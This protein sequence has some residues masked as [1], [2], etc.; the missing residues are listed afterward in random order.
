VIQSPLRNFEKRTPQHSQHERVPQPSVENLLI[1]QGKQIR[2]LYEL[3]KL[4]FNKLT[5]VQ[6]QL[7]KLTNNKNTE[8]SPKVFS[9]SSH[10]LV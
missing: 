6:G 9:V 7:K 1:K 2:A 10:N 5:S 8:L 4:T 3:Q